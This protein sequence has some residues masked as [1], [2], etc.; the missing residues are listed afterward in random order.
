MACYYY[1]MFIRRLYLVSSL[2]VI[3]DVHF[4]EYE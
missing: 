1:G 3:I 4:R 2:S